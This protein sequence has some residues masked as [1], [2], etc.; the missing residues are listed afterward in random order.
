MSSQRWKESCDRK[1]HTLSID[2]LMLLFDTSVDGLDGNKAQER[3]SIAGLNRLVIA[4]GNSVW[5]IFFS[6][7]LNPLVF[8]LLLACI[9]KFFIAGKLDAV[10]IFSTVLVMVFIGFFQEMKA[11]NAMQSLKKLYCFSS[12]VKRD[13]KVI[14]IKS[15]FIAPGDI[16]I[17][18]AG[19]KIPVDG[20]IIDHHS[21]RVNEASLTGESVAIEKNAGYISPETPLAERKNMVY[22]GTT[23]ATGKALVLCVATAMNTEMGKIALAIQQVK[24]EKTPLQKSIHSLS[25]WISGVVLVIIFVFI[26]ISLYKGYSWLDIILFSVSAAIAAI[27][28]GLPAAVTI[29]LATGMQVMAKRNALIRRLCSVETLGSTTLIASDKTGTLTRNQMVVEHTYI[30]DKNEQRQKLLFEIGVLANDA[31]ITKKED[32]FEIIGDPSE[33]A[34]LIAAEKEGID[35]VALA[36]KCPRIDEIPFESEK[37]FMA[38][39]CQTDEGLKVFIKGSPE[40]ILSMSAVSEI[41]RKEIEEQVLHF[42]G[43]GL[44][45]LAAGCMKINTQSAFSEWLMQGKIDF[46]GFFAM[47][48]PPRDEVKLAIEKCG[49]AGIKVVMITGDNK[50]TAEAIAS[51]L[52][53]MSEA[54][55]FTGQQIDSQKDKFMSEQIDKVGVFARIEP[56]HKL[57]IVRAF[58]NLGYVVAMTGDGVNDAPALEAADIGISMGI[59]GT[60]VAK[61]ASD[62]ILLDDNFSTIVA[63]VEEGRAIFNRIRFVTTFLLITCFGELLGLM[64]SVAFTE[65]VYLQP[66]QILWINLITGVIVAFPLA[67]EPKSGDELNNPPRAPDVKLIYPGMVLRILFLATSLGLSTFTVY[68]YVRSYVDLSVA[69]TMV[70]SSLVFFEWLIAFNMRSDE[71]TLFQIGPLSNKAL[72]FPLVFG[73]CMQLS[74]V[75]VPLL[76]GMFQT[77]FLDLRQWLI[78][79]IPGLAVFA[80]ET[81]RKI[82]FPKLFNFGKWRRRQ[83]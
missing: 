71:K 12:K 59:A 79:L 80:L 6:Q 23:V 64:L 32:S 15:D 42:S 66:L 76:Q 38:T 65:N 56:M 4:N 75:Y 27:P 51:K 74:I 77:A 35:H 3:I 17:L 69:R 73:F 10:L 53:I 5:T 11:E 18:E 67:L 36:K 9:F 31:Y 7:F 78:A 45:L 82:Y 83:Y 14:V 44:R 63:A 40:K 58:K 33:A 30:C 52:G 62:M 34:L 68:Y 25:L 81:L 24:P 8:I 47:I 61:E 39:L 29:V 49:S 70:F 16:V 19:D 26:A 22:T 50:A 37:R 46:V 43:Q 57:E 13:G 28:E 1:W 41:K 60:D 21:F 55:A 72:I 20:R 54:G 2:E 48:D